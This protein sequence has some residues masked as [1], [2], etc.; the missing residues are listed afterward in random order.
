VAIEHRIKSGPLLGV[1][2]SWR[3]AIRPDKS[4]PNVM[5][6]N[7]IVKAHVGSSFLA[8]VEPDGFRFV[9]V[10]DRLFQRL[11]WSLEGEMLEG[12]AVER[13]GSLKSTYQRC[14]ERQAPCYEF[15]RCDFGDGDITAFERLT[16]P[17]AGASGG[18]SH[19]GGTVSFDDDL[20]SRH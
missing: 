14:V 5:A 8:S 7:A 6:F 16:L 18:V 13:F 11:G 15:L 12:D 9:S 4:L 10:G 2:Q 20:A 19:V 3:A 1:M 17:F